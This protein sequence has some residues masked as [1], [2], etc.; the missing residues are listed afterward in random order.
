MSQGLTQ[1]SIGAILNL[2]ITN[3][4]DRLGSF[5]DFIPDKYAAVEK[6]ANKEDE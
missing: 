4:G 6:L 2:I 1:A 3:F 5:A